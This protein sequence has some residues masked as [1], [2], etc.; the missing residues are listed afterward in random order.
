[1]IDGPD[2][3]QAALDQLPIDYRAVLVLKDMEGKRFP[4]IA[5]LLQV[6]VP[7]VRGRLHEARAQLAKLLQREVDEGTIEG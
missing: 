6:P 5:E 7:V 2:R 4:E 1:M 3:L